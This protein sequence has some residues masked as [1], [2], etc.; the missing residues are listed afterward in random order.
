MQL[1]GSLMVTFTVPMPETMLWEEPPLQLTMIPAIP[2]IATTASKSAPARGFRA[3]Q[4]DFMVLLLLKK[5]FS[6]HSFAG[7][8][9]RYRLDSRPWLGCRGL[10]ELGALNGRDYSTNKPDLGVL[11][12]LTP[13]SHLGGADL[14]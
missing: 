2:K 12:G 11:G 5:N 14:N 8:G 9:Q 7:R 6:D 3:I 13:G 4:S 1:G 10:R